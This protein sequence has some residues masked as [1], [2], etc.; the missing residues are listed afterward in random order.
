[1]MKAA[2]SKRLGWGLGLV[3]LVTAGGCAADRELAIIRNDLDRINRQLLQLQVAQEVSQTKPRELVQRELEGERRNIA[4]MKASLDEL[5][6]QVGVLA[7]RLEESGHRLNQRISTLEARLPGGGAATA[8]PPPGGPTSPP[9]PMPSVA[10]PPP[11]SGT[12]TPT[13]SPGSAEVKRLY[14]AAL[15]DYQRGK[16][17][18][19]VQGFRSY[20][21]QAPRGDVADTAQYYLAES[22][23]SAKDYRNAIAEFE[24]LVRDYPQS[25]QVPSA[26]LKT[27]YAYYEIKDNMQGRR[28]L[29][30]LIEKYPLSREAKLAEERLRLEDRA[31]AGR[32]TAGSP[33]PQPTTAKPQSR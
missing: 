29:R 33:T 14:Q 11:P 27:G 6:Q 4:D 23:Y 30:T 5:R 16:F 10:G 2:R 15:T 28:A 20:L 22:L 8:T 12:P 32:P 31:G 17:D 18:L 9:S 25:P 3:A 7:E 1:M 13:D 26:L 24:R 19:A 21:Q